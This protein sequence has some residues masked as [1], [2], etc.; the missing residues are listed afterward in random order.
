[1][2]GNG[3]FVKQPRLVFCKSVFPEANHLPGVISSI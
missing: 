1:M 3:S 2:N